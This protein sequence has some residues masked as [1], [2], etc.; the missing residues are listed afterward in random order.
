VWQM[1]GSNQR[2]LSRR[3]YSP[4]LL[5]EAM[6]L[7]STYAVRDSIPGRVR[8]LYVRAH[9]AWS[10]DGGGKTHGRGRWERLHRPSA[11]L[12]ASELAFQDACSLP[13]SARHRVRTRAVCLENGKVG[14]LYKA[15]APVASWFNQY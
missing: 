11:R 2:R 4:S 3:F 10:T 1:L 9:R 8:P 15:P 13:S 6:P 14:D 12:L 7:T 5:S